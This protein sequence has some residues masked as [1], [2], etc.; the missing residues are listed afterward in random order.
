MITY[1]IEEVNG[2]KQIVCEGQ[3]NTYALTAEKIVDELNKSVRIQQKIRESQEAL[4]QV[5]VEL[6]KITNLNFI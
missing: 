6:D 4:N 1:R 5:W 3:Y 2:M